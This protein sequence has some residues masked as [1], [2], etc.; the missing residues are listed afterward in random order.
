MQID[1]EFADPK[2][3]SDAAKTKKLLARREELAREQSELEEEWIRKS[4]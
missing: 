3:A 4:G 1:F 2:T